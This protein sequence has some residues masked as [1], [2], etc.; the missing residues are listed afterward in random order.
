MG[1]PLWTSEECKLLHRSIREGKTMRELMKILNRPYNSVKR[2]I[3]NENRRRPKDQKLIPGRERF[4]WTEDELRMA[5]QMILQGY[6]DSC[7][8]QH[9]NMPLVT[10]HSHKSQ[11]QMSKRIRRWTPEEQKHFEYLMHKRALPEEIAAIL[12]R[13][14]KSITAHACESGMVFNPEG[15]YFHERKLGL[16][17]KEIFPQYDI[18][19]IS[20]LGILG[21]QTVDYYIPQLNTAFEYDGEQHFRPVC[22]G[23]I[24]LHRAQTLFKRTQCLDRRKNRLCRLY[25]IRL[26]RIPYTEDL[27]IDNIKKKLTGK[28]V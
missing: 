26:I 5:K 4:W 11:Y 23:G 16:L 10:F 6:S 27:T 3:Y 24:P 7:I 22:F 8:A 25:D 12:N 18:V 1:A 9:F 14:V 19:Y 15:R 17:L 28:E 13:T 20:N 21:R 2:K